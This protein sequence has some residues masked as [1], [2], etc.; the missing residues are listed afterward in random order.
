[1]FVFLAIHRSYCAVTVKQMSET[2]YENATLCC[3]PTHHGSGALQPF[4]G[5]VC[6]I[7]LPIAGQ[8]N[9]GDVCSHMPIRGKMDV[10]VSDHSITAGAC[11]Y[12]PPKGHNH[13]SARPPYGPYHPS[14]GHDSPSHRSP[15]RP[16]HPPKGHN[17][18]SAR[19]PYGPYHPPKGHDSPSHRSPSRP[20]QPPSPHSY[21]SVSPSSRPNPAPTSS[22]ASDVITQMNWPG[23]HGFSW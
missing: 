7:Q 4:N 3:A 19:P 21:P 17:H 1:M 16:Y 9:W 14:K 10:C 2:T 13:P 15:S 11:P 18:P 12:H 23:M 5:L 8:A 6:D 20:S 22:D